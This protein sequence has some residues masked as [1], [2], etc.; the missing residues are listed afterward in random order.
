LANVLK[1]RLVLLR[2]SRGADSFPDFQKRDD[3][4]VIT[5]DDLR[6]WAVTGFFIFKILRY[7]ECRFLTYRLELIPRPFFISFLIRFMTRGECVVRDDLGRV[8]HITWKYVAQRFRRWSGERSRASGLIQWIKGQVGEL[9]SHLNEKK[10]NVLD[11]GLSPAYLRTDMAFGVRSGGPVSHIAGVL[12]HLDSFTGPPFFLTTDAIPTVRKDIETQV[13]QPKEG[14]WDFRELPS[15]AF[16]EVFYLLANSSIGEEPLSFIYQRYSLNDYSG[17]RLA[18][19]KNLPFVLEYNGSEIKSGLRLGKFLK[20][21]ALSKRIEEVNL[22]AADLVVVVSRPLKDELTARG[23]ESEK[24]LINPN[25]VD[26]DKYSPQVDGSPVRKRYGLEE[27]KVLGFIGTFGKWHGAEVLARAFAELARGDTKFREE[28]RLLMVGDGITMPLVKEIL[29]RYYVKDLCV[30][31][32]TLPQAEGPAYLA[33]CDI[34]VE[35]YVPNQD[36]TP[37]FGSPTKLFEYMAMGKGIVASKL[38]QIGEILK[39]NETALMV[40]SGDK[41][42]LKVGLKV[43]TGD[44]A[45]S[46]RLGR[47]AREECVAKYTWKEHTRKIIEKLKERCG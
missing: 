41:D 26:T 8:R 36:G 35:P 46:D 15:L 5:L 37:F 2:D 17:V 1:K 28:T 18:R 40:K 14:Y 20:Y 22:K 25:G 39:P 6:Y 30:L 45:L 23:V 44:K 42:S 29:G 38:G 27:K 4:E 33:A 21:E 34:L 3:D 32:G 31:T 12:N 19:D 24:I 9:E 13:L 16:N 47:A 11:L 7:S 10:K 43:L